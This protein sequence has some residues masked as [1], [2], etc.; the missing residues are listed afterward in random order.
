MS[1][2]NVRLHHAQP[3]SDKPGEDPMIKTILVPAGG[4]D[5][6]N[7]VFASALTVARAFAAHIDFLHV[8]VDPSAMAATMAAD[9]GGATMLGGLISR[10]EQEAGQREEKARQLVQGFCERE[11]L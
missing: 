5:S 11:G 9:G 4:S 1:A 10:I 3:R 8:A 2:S 6:D 7:A